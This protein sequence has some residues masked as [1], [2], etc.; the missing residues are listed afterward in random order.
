MMFV[1][2]LNRGRDISAQNL[3]EALSSKHWQTRVAALKFIDEKGLEIS[4]FKS[5]PDLLASAHIAERYWLAKTL[6]NSENRATYDA[7]INFLKDP[8][9]NVVTMALYAI[10]KRG[11]RDVVDKIL[12]LI[13]TT[14]S[15]YI[16]WYAYKALR[17]IGW[18]QSK[19]KQAP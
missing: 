2:Q 13:E 3:L 1:F 8:S 11:N 15:W 17:S 5:Y 14:D 7:L 19:S 12:Q 6:G 10:G 16:Q 9:P 4:R 18:R